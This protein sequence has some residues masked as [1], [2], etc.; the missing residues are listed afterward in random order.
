MTTVR[1]SLKVPMKRPEAS[2]AAIRNW[3]VAGGIAGPTTN[4]K[5]V[6][7]TEKAPP[8]PPNPLIGSGAVPRG[9]VNVKFGPVYS[10]PYVTAPVTGVQANVFGLDRLSVAPLSGASRIGRTALGVGVGVGTGVA[11]GVGAGVGTGP[12]VGDGAGMF[13]VRASLKVPMNRPAASRAAIR[14]WNVPAGTAGSMLIG[15]EVTPTVK[16]PPRP[17]SPLIGSGAVPREFV[18]ERLGPVNS[19]R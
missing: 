11:V 1:A 3:Y 19:N 12:G 2:R 8:R 15:P 9:F 18:N 14:N 5:V 16:P 7:P 6:T 4:G 10:M 13:T 17:P